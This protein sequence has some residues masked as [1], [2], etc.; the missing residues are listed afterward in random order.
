MEK[1]NIG[2]ALCSLNNCVKRHVESTLSSIDSSGATGTNSWIIGFIAEN[3]DR[4]IYQRDLE[5]HF[6][7]TRS[8]A[9]KNVELMVQK[10]LIVRQSVSH[11]AR[12]KKLELTPIAEEIAEKMRLDRDRMDNQ[13]TNGFNDEELEQ[14]YSFLIRMK[15]NMKVVL[16][17]S[18]KYQSDLEKNKIF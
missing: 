16:N 5:T 17:N 8:T 4:D 2:I 10:G 15:E 14:L 1:K 9:S 3:S 11:D 13:L 7:I 6:G 12:L 18:E